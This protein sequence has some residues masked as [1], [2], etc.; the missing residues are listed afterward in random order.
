MCMWVI[1][2][3]W[4]P[5]FGYRVGHLPSR[6]VCASVAFSV[7]DPEGTE[8]LRKQKRGEVTCTYVH[9]DRPLKEL[10][11]ALKSRVLQVRDAESLEKSGPAGV[12]R[13]LA[14]RATAPSRT[15]HR[16]CKVPWPSPACVRRSRRDADLTSFAQALQRAFQQL[17]ETGLL[18]TSGTS[19]RRWQSDLRQGPSAGQTG[20]APVGGGHEDPDCRGHEGSATS[21][22]G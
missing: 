7:P 12:E 17:E 22:G 16:A 10:R 8:K 6:D 4:A 5:P 21:S 20:F 15:N 11:S 19:A 1:T 18:E 13:V 3:G 14:A 9:D 2:G